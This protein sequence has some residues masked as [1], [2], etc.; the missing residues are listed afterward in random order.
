MEIAQIVGIGL[1]A[2]VFILVVKEYR[3]ELA[4]QMSVV[5]GVFIFFIVLGYVRDVISVLIDLSVRADINL[6]F[7]EILLRIIGIAYIAEF[8]AQV[9][10]DAG[11]GS[12]AGKIEFAAKILILVIAL[13]IV[14]AVIESIINFLP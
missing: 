8:G 12:T 14:T 2:T 6:I 7:L 10:R 9:C 5:V 13:P 4:L 3:P 11:E 1:I